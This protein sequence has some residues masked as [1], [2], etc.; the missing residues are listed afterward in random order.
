MKEVLMIF[1]DMS[2]LADFLIDHNV[3][4]VEINSIEQTLVAPLR[5]EEIIIAIE[6]YGGYLK[7]HIRREPGSC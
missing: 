7:T 6:D 3:S 4:N 5:E 1:P 2:R